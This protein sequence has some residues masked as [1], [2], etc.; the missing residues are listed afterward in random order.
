MWKIKQFLELM[1]CLSIIFTGI[2]SV[3]F[4]AYISNGL[5]EKIANIL[6]KGGMF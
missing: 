5:P 1:Y 2:S 6:I 3:I 4:F